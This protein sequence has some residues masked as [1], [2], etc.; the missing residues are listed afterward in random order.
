[1]ENGKVGVSTNEESEEVRLP[2]L[3]GPWKGCNTGLTCP[4]GDVLFVKF[5]ETSRF[6]PCEGPDR[7]VSHIGLFQMWQRLCRLFA[8]VMGSQSLKAHEGHYCAL[9]H[10]QRRDVAFGEQLPTL[11]GSWC[12]KP[13]DWEGC[14]VLCGLSAPV[15]IQHHYP[16]NRVSQND[17]TKKKVKLIWDTL[18]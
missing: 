15:R 16:Y 7:S 11:V 8:F 9:I 13:W 12:A 3:V 1:M 2:G 10:D 6:T 4:C 18:L 14:L 17:Y 5:M